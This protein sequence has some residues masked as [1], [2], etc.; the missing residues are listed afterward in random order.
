MAQ[1]TVTNGESGL[2]SRN[3]INDNFTELYAGALGYT[4]ADELTQ[5]AGLTLK[6]ILL[7]RNYWKHWGSLPLFPFIL[8]IRSPPV[9]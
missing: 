3:K 4:P 1:Q 5:V 2:I 6:P 9:P 8:T 7:P